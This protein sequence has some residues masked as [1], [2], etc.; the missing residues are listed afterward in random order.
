[1]T[2]EI[3]ELLPTTEV[4][5]LSRSRAGIRYQQPSSGSRAWRASGEI[6]HGRSYRQLLRRA[7][8]I[9]RHRDIGLQPL[10]IQNLNARR[11]ASRGHGALI[12][13]HHQTGGS[14]ATGGSDGDPG[15]RGCSGFVRRQ[16]QC[17]SSLGRCAPVGRHHAD[18]L[19]GGGLPFEIRIESETQRGHLNLD[20]PSTKV[21]WK[22]RGAMAAQ[23]VGYPNVEVVGSRLWWGFRTIRRALAVMLTIPGGWA[24]M[25]NV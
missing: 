21:T 2:F 7:R 10:R 5:K 4:V 8:D 17:G 3:Q 24:S 20:A 12:D 13:A 22:G 1:M 16:R 18:G 25:E 11:I 15:G 9:E 14:R 6:Q 19:R 23:A